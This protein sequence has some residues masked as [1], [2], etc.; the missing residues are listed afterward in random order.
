MNWFN[1]KKQNKEKHLV[2]GLYDEN[3][4]E[5]SVKGYS[6]LEIPFS[7]FDQ[8]EEGFGAVVLSNNRT[9]TWDMGYSGFPVKVR[10][11]LLIGKKSIGG[12][13]V[14]KTK[15]V[16]AYTTVC[17]EKGAMKVTFHC[18]DDIEDFLYD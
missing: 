8:W 12:Q 4:V 5:L 15:M 18:K 16:N 9:I 7:Y 13:D 3:Q 1:N 2:V 6:R 14:T 10:G 11:C 17:F